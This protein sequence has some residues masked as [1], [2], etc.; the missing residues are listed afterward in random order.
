MTRIAI[1]LIAAAVFT[2]CAAAPSRT[3]TGDSLASNC[4]RAHQQT[5]QITL[6]LEPVLDSCL[7]GG[8]CP[9]VSELDA[10]TTTVTTSTA[11]L[12]M[13]Y[14]PANLAYSRT[15]AHRV[16]GKLDRVARKYGNS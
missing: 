11:C 15:L 12:Q 5:Q 13:G 14:L 2:G 4:A 9:V 7:A 6:R 10:L 8:R 16:S 1:T 3:T